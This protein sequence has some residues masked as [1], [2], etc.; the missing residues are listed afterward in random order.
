MRYEAGILDHT[1][2]VKRAGGRGA[3]EL[4]IQGPRVSKKQE[5]AF[6]SGVEAQAH[7]HSFAHSALQE[8][9]R[10]D[11]IRWNGVPED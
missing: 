4:S 10:C 2:S 9:C 1:L 5:R 6:A 11:D 8:P 3:Y 7:A